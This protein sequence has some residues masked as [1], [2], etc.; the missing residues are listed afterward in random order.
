MKRSLQMVSL[1]AV[2]GLYAAGQTAMAAEQKCASGKHCAIG[3]QT[4]T[5]TIGSATGGAGAGKNK[6]TKPKSALNPQPLPPGM[7]HQPSTSK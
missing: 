1:I 3:K 7:K 4:G 6:E 2:G 5:A